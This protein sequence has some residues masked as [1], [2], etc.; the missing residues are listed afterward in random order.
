EPR[1]AHRN[2]TAQRLT[3]S[4][5]GTVAEPD[6]RG[7]QAGAL[8]TQDLC[9]LQRNNR[10]APPM[11]DMQQRQI[12][13]LCDPNRLTGINIH[14][15]SRQEWVRSRDS[16]RYSHADPHGENGSHHGCHYTTSYKAAPT[17]SAAAGAAD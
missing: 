10:T 2:A 5:F 3:T 1:P 11:I 16:N 9:A 13:R 4:K 12:P 17:R 7:A 14:E 6:Q 15:H 8:I